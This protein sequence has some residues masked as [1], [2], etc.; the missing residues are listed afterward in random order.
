MLGWSQEILHNLFSDVEIIASE[1]LN[2][3]R[4]REEGGN[5]K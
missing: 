1:N 5:E 4:E 2:L 3:E